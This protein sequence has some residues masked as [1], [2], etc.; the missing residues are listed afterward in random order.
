MLES[1]YQSPQQN[2]SMWE[3]VLE[4]EEGES[5]GLV[6]LKKNSPVAAGLREALKPP[7]GPESPKK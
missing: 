2:K 5:A 7:E 6:F 1:K 4:L 3:R